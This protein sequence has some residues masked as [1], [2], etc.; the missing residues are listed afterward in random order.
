MEFE[1]G[2]DYRLRQLRARC[3]AE[4]LVWFDFRELCIGPRSAADYIEIAR[5]H[6]RVLISRI[7]VL[8][9]ASDDAARLR[10][11]PHGESAARDAGPRVSRKTAPAQKSVP[12]Q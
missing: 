8:D 11:P 7:P 4:D 5:C 6:R 1:A 12:S 10:V 9:A 3:E 2:V